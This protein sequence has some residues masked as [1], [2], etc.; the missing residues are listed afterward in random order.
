M[1]YWETLKEILGALKPA[2]DFTI[3]SQHTQF[4]LSDFYLGWKKI[5]RKFEK[6]IEKNDST[7]NLA[8]IFLSHLDLRKNVLFNHPLML[9]AI[10]LDPRVRV[11]LVQNQIQISKMKL[12]DL[13]ERIEAL[14]GENSDE[15]NKS[16]NPDSFDDFD[17]FVKSQN[18]HIE[19]ESPKMDRCTFYVL[20]E[21][22]EST[23]SSIWHGTN[24]H[25]F[26]ENAKNKFPEIYTVAKVINAIP[27]TQTSV[28]RAF[29][30]LGFVFDCRRTKISEKNLENI[31][32]IKLNSNLFNT[33]NEEEIRSLE[34][35][36][37]KYYIKLTAMEV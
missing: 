29:S 21:T 15:A 27:P 9:C 11:F 37:C 30:T 34:D 26:W 16:V 20:L 32:A 4:T 5:E 7:T 18:H 24:I 23:F 14:E 6:E 17:E 19:I 8:T 1:K 28:E 31:L 35:P 13:F 2:Y 10:Y 36:A 33:I 12:F 22:F 25:E 3:A